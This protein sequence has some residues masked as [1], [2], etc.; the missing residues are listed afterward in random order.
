MNQIIVSISQQRIFLLDCNGQALLDYPVSTSK[1]GVG[2]ENGSFKTPL[3]KHVV[4]QK[5][6]DGCD[7][8]EVFVGRKAIGKLTVL[9]AEN[10]PLPEDVIM[11]RI[12]RLRGL[13][14]GLNQ[15]ENIDS[16]QRYIYIHGTSEENK[17]GQPASHGCVRLRNKNMIELF[18]RIEEGSPVNIIE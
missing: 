7:I 9:R 15:G 10:H 2:S 16:Y 17:I 4:V 6:G 18:D 8:E 12:V 3:G 1:F 13:E 5:I 14:P 11:S